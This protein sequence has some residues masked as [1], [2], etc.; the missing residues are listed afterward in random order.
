MARVKPR[1]NVYALMPVLATLIMGVGIYFTWQEVAPY[2]RELEPKERPEQ[3]LPYVED[4]TPKAKK[5]DKAKATES[6]TEP[7]GERDEGPAPTEAPDAGPAPGG[8]PE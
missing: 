5:D 4:R 1:P 7:G 3:R 8:G 2:T 6:D